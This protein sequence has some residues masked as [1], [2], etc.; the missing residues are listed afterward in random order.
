M[1]KLASSVNS[2]KEFIQIWVVKYL[3]V[4]IIKGFLNITHLLSSYL[5][6]GNC[7]RTKFGGENLHAD[8][9]NDAKQHID[10]H[11]YSAIKIIQISK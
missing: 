3:N 10:S 7:L 9:N 5:M 4:I 6:T 1:T 8:I 2:S 11:S